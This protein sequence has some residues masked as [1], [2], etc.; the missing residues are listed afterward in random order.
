MWS[1]DATYVR[2]NARVQAMLDR[3]DRPYTLLCAPAVS[4]PLLVL[5]DQP[6]ATTFDAEFDDWSAAATVID[7]DQLK[8]RLGDAIED[9]FCL[10][11]REEILRVKWFSH[12]T[13]SAA[14]IYG[15]E[16]WGGATEYE[17]CWLFDRGE[18]ERVLLHVCHSQ[19]VYERRRRLLFGTRA[20]RKEHYE[21][22]VVQLTA[23]A[24]IEEPVR[25]PLSLFQKAAEYMGISAPM[26]YFKPHMRGFDWNQYRVTPTRE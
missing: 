9:Y 14:M 19:V 21:R 26:G 12:A 11:E 8:S 22:A 15:T 10:P 6:Y 17:W 24:I 7:A 1:I 23:D 3:L 16:T 2:H 25:H 13:N 20:I 4:L 5:A 18:D